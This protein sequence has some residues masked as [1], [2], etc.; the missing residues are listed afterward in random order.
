MCLIDLEPCE[1]WEE[2][3]YRARIPHACNCCRRAIRPGLRYMQ[4]FMVFEG[5]ANTERCCLPCWR[6]NGIFADAHE[7]MRCTPSSFVD[8]LR[9][10]IDENEPGVGQWKRMLRR[11]RARV[12]EVMT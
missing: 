9:E 8:A 7:G 4:V 10:C 1:V 2:R 5:E 11:I 3:L 6:A 12:P